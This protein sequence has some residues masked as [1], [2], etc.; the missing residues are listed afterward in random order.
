VKPSD[1]ERL[2]LH[3]IEDLEFLQQESGPALKRSREWIAD[4]SGVSY[5]ARVRS[6]GHSDPTA[7][8]MFDQID[9]GNKR[10]M[11][12]VHEF[13]KLARRARGWVEGLRPLDQ[14]TARELAEA[15]R[16]NEAL[17]EE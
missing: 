3:A 14:P 16:F 12:D 4:I 9:R 8:R 15:E 2:I 17:G 10:M 1:L 13:A 5:E 7:K 6:G 11:R